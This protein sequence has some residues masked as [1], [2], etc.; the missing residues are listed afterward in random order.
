[1]EV[2][3]LLELDAMDESHSD[4]VFCSIQQLKVLL[5]RCLG[6]HS[7]WRMLFKGHRD[8]TLLHFLS[9]KHYKVQIPL[10]H[11]CLKLKVVRLRKKYL[12]LLLVRIEYMLI[13]FSEERNESE[14]ELVH[15]EANI[16]RLLVSDTVPSDLDPIAVVLVVRKGKP[17]VEDEE[18]IRSIAVAVPDL[19]PFFVPWPV[20]AA[21][22]QVSV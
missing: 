14:V 12:P 2:Q 17:I 1:M 3:D 15:L 10:H 11:I 13:G 16:L 20:E 7:D 22:A 4:I 6:L 9:L 5:Q 21:V 8:F 18:C 19:I